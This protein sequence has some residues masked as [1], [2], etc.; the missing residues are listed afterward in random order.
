MGLELPGG[1]DDP[2]VLVLPAD[3]DVISEFTTAIG[4]HRHFER[5]SDPPLV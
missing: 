2:G 4:K 3:V 1:E 5:Q